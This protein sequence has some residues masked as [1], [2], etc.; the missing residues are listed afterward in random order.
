MS[1]EVPTPQGC[2]QLERQKQS[3]L[4]FTGTQE[5]ISF[6]KH[7]NHD[8]ILMHLRKYLGDVRVLV[9]G[10]D[11]HTNPAVNGDCSVSARLSTSPKRIEDIVNSFLACRVA[12]VRA[13]RAVEVLV[14]VNF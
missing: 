9:G 5:P 3:P 12:M 4:I 6:M 1:F 14:D 13:I 7:V 8:R 10:V 11:E 2:V